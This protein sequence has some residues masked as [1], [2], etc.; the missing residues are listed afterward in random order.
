MVEDPHRRTF[1]YLMELF[2]SEYQGLESL[3][4]GQMRPVPGFRALCRAAIGLAECFRKLHNM[5]ACY[6]DIN[7]GGP[8]IDPRTGEV[9][10]CDTDNVRVNKTPGNILFVFFAA[11]ELIRGEGL[12]QTNT[13]IH[14]LAVLL[15]YL[16]FRHHPLEGK[17]ELSVNV[18]NEAA[19]RKFYGREPV[20]IFDPDN[21]SNRPVAGFHDSAIRNWKIYPSFLKDLF[22]RAFTEGLREPD[23]RVREGEWMEAF[24]RL[25]DQLYY[26]SKCG[27]GN[28]LDTDSAGPS[29]C[30]RCGEIPQL[31]M[32]LEI[33]DRIVLLNH[34]TEIYPHHVGRSLDFGS[35]IAKVSQHPENPDRWGI[36]NCSE[37][38]WAFVGKGGSHKTCAPGRTVPLRRDLEL[39]F[40]SVPAHV[41]QH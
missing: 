14:S 40:G 29:P 30:W 3:V 4:L 31:P 37:Q 19:Q 33:N 28:F 23:R 27:T 39:L 9:L 11:P 41:R 35:P 15:F 5:G 16:F 8:V 18:F 10:V 26:C 12:C 32:R 20:F 6:K 13:D 25:R 22:I 38:P 7:L 1:G 17:K 2:P 24:S 34:D 36:M 21:S